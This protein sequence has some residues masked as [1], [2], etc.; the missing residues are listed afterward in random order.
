METVVITR[1]VWTEAERTM[2]LCGGLGNECVVYL[3][4]EP[5]V[6]RSVARATAVYHPAHTGSATSYEVPISELL[7]LNSSLFENRLSVLAQVHTHPGQAF[8]SGTDDRWPTIETVGFLSLVVP[9]FC[10]EG[11]SG[12]AGCYLAEYLGSGQWREVS[13]A[14]MLQRLQLE[15]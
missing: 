10:R 11:L 2:R 15:Q 7:K 6:G 14:E 4:G 9:C 1:A 8:H 3:C 12:L 13:R 5:T